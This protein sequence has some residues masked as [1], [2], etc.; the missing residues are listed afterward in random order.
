MR[1]LRTRTP[2]LYPSCYRLPKTRAVATGRPPAIGA[3][4]VSR[5]MPLVGSSPHAAPVARSKKP[6][7]IA[8]L[9]SLATHH[10]ASGVGVAK[11]T[12][13][14]VVV[15]DLR[16]FCDGAVTAMRPRGYLCRRRPPPVA[17]ALGPVAAQ[18]HRA[19]LTR[20]VAG[21]VVERPAAV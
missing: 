2:W 6:P 10:A 8:S 11:R 3:G 17:F 5:T 9:A 20:A 19:P 18:A 21:A 4:T 1:P 13:R 12:T 15:A 16:G 14:T 7:T